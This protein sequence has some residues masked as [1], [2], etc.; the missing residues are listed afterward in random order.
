MKNRYL[1]VC[2]VESVVSNDG[3]LRVSKQPTKCYGQSD[4]DDTCPCYINNAKY[5]IEP[6]KREVQG[7]T[8]EIGKAYTIQYYIPT[9][10][11]RKIKKMFNLSYKSNPDFYDCTVVINRRK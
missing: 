4:W 10:L 6:T 8:A 3:I 1:I 5:T 7:F 9:K 2:C 11:T